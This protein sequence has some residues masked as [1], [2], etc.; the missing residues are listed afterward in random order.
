M[1]Y[2]KPEK[3]MIERLK[4]STREKHKQLNR[5]PPFYLKKFAATKPTR[6]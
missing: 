2:G 3:P 6:L 5:Y 1:S 4:N